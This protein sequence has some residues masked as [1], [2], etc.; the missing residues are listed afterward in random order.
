MKMKV[1]GGENEGGYE[2][3]YGSVENINLN[4]AEYIG[5]TVELGKP[6]QGDVKSLKFTLKIVR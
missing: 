5:K 3:E 6:T 1:A 4:E 2:D